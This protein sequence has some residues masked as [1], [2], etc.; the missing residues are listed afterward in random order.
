MSKVI[1]DFLFKPDK[2]R[3]NK[4][5]I[6]NEFKRISSRFTELRFQ[7]H[8]LQCYVQ[9]RSDQGQNGILGRRTNEAR[10]GNLRFNQNS[11]D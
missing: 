7:P 10:E 4:T 9:L 6:S 3:V 8:K 1:C 5:I 11:A 2:F